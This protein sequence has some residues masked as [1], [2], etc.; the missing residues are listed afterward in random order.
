MRAKTSGLMGV[1]IVTAGCAAG[2]SPSELRARLGT[3]GASGGGLSVLVFSRTEGFRHG[4]IDVAIP[5]LLQMGTARGW[6]VEATEDPAVFVPGDLL[7]SASAGHSASVSARRVG[8]NNL[9]RSSTTS[10]SDSVVAIEV[11]LGRSP[12]AWG[13]TPRRNSSSSTR[14]KW[15][16]A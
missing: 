16:I 10:R 14:V 7:S 6:S 2:E 8:S 1:G 3:P 9:R 4:S 5:A 11:S 12:C 13:M 15:V